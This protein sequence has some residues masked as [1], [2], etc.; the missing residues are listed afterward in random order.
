MN[1]TGIPEIKIMNN[2]WALASTYLKERRSYR[3]VVVSTDD[4]K[5]QNTRATVARGG[6]L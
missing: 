6:G 5:Y 1:Q 4:K 2:V 3:D